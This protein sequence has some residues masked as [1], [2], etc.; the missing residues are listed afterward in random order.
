MRRE[1]GLTLVELLIAASIFS[2]II[3]TIYSAF[4]TG[5]LSYRK[6]D[7]AFDVYQTARLILNRMELDL[8]NSFVFTKKDS[9]FQGNKTS[10][11]FFSPVDSFSEGK[12]SLD[13]CHI[14]YELSNGILNRA[15]YK[16]LDAL[17]GN[18]ESPIEEE[19][20]SDVKELSFEYAYLTGDLDEP[21]TWQEIWPSEDPNKQEEQ[22]KT[23]PLAVKIKLSLIEKNKLQNVV[24]F[25]KTV[26]L[27][28]SEISTSLTSPGGGVPP[29]EE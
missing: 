5:I 6:I 22:K 26:S 1:H 18:P 16:G 12:S 23:L 29:S 4:H 3:L 28:L 9:K 13:L 25:N 10:I 17:K 11:N 15:C 24:N 19:L 8:K 7:S 27:P 21:Y 20:S 14:K 2:V